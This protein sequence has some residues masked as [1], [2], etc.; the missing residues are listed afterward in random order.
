MPMS[1]NVSAYYDVGQVLTAARKEGGGMYDLGT[2][3]AATHWRMRAYYYRTLLADADARAH[4]GVPGY[5]PTTEWDDMTLT[6]QGSAV[7]IE[8]GTVKGTL[9]NLQGKPL[10]VKPLKKATPLIKADDDED[11]YEQAR[12]LAEEKGK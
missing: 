4:A 9:T 11:L 5:M 6:L 1:K 7:V 3:K 2:P 8:F 10:E 12:R